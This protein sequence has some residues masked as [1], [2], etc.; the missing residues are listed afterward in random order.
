MV[1][2]KQETTWC[3]HDCGVVNTS[4]GYKKYRNIFLKEYLK[5][6][7]PLVTIMITAYNRP[8][9]F[10]IALESA[11]NQTYKNIEIVVC[12]NSTNDECNSVIEPFLKEYKNIR[13]YKNEIELEI[14]DN[15]Q[16][17]LV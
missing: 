10:K 7:F 6:V 8:I 11:I 17:V 2:P 3:I 5:D 14:I 12:D 4:N 15:L 13:Y 9:Y 16:N 1:V